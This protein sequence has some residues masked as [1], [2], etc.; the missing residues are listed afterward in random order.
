M[1]FSICIESVFR[2]MNP[3][4]ALEKVK[5]CGF[6]AF[7]FWGW[8]NKDMEA[9]FKKAAS[10]SLTCTAFCTSA[11][12]LNDPAKRN[13]YLEGLKES[14]AAARKAGCGFLISQA[15]LDTGAVR[16]FQHKSVVAGLKAA[17]SILEGSGVTLLLEPLNGRVDHVGTYL[18]SSD[19]G[20][21]IL[22]EVG[23]ENI[24]LLFDIYHQQITEGDIIRRIQANLKNIAHF[25]SA[26]SPG[27]NE[28]YSG[29]LNYRK[30]F[31]TIKSLG[32]KGFF[33]LEYFPKDDPVEGL[34]RIRDS[35]I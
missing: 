25:H 1:E 18:E 15:G 2:G 31:E 32:Y 21:Q 35:L 24:K 3:L 13:D 27:R 29:E 5:E 8:K 26:G 10:L 4:D 9:L 30:V 7:E 6:R 17:A 19:E 34:K 33:G 14:V 11:F 20:F 23:C 22:N 28:L 16:S 12:I